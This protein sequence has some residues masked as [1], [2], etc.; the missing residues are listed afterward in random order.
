MPVAGMAY[1]DRPTQAGYFIFPDLSV[2]HE[3]KFRL[4]FNLYEE[5]KEAKDM[6]PEGTVPLAPSHEGNG[7]MRGNTVAHVHFRLEVKSAPFTVYSAKKFPGLAEST[8][9][10]RLVAEQGCRVRIRRDVR[11]RR[12]EAKPGKEYDGYSDDEHQAYA[13]ENRYATPESYHHERASS[14]NG[15]P[16]TIERRPSVHELPGYYPPPPPMAQ[17]PPPAPQQS[18]S[19]PPPP[20]PQSQGYSHL[21]FGATAPPY[22]PGQ[23]PYQPANSPYQYQ[24]PPPAPHHR[25]S[26]SSGSNYAY[27]P[28]STYNQPPSRPP[29]PDVDYNNRPRAP[30]GATYTYSD[31]P[32]VDQS[33]AGPLHPND[34]RSATPS[35]NTPQLPPLKCLTETKYEQPP[36]PNGVVSSP[37]AYEPHSVPAPAP[38]STPTSAPP[39]SGGKRSYGR[40]FDDGQSNGL[41]NGARPDAV[42]QDFLQVEC[43]DG[44]I[45]AENELPDYRTL[46]YR[47]A[48]GSRQYKKINP[49]S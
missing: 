19:H 13:P 24:Q 6:D 2:R 43:E 33:Y 27:P 30:S 39:V 38:A 25:P 47:R 15:N 42:G 48:D 3:G 44:S 9:L 23:P 40:T 14:V 41:H 5:L 18:Y 12:R 21:Q 7:M 22:Q 31:L 45:V 20:A 10:S 17:Q 29:Y 28:R 46:T 11:M 32:A 26:S 34:L 8:Q 16:P 1:L 35:N 49:Y 4:S 36:T 37:A